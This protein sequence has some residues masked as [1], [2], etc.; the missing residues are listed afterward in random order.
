MSSIKR[1]LP[2]ISSLQQHFDAVL[3]GKL[4]DFLSS[5]HLRRRA[6]IGSRNY[7]LFAGVFSIA[8][9]FSLYFI[10]DRYDDV[11]WEIFLVCAILWLLVV[12]FS[13]RQ[14]LTDT[15]LLS[16]EMNM[17]LAPLISSA[18]NRTVIYSYDVTHREETEKLL[19]E[20]SLMTID[21]IKLVSDDVLT[22]YGDAELSMRELV[23]TKQEVTRQGKK[24]ALLLFKGVFV[25]AKLP[26]THQAETYISTD[27]DRSGFAHRTF[28]TTVLENTSI[29]E[30][31]LEWNDFEN[32]LHVA[33]NDPVV[34]RELL[35][36]DFMQD[37]YDWWLEHKLN[38][39]IAFKGDKFY[40]LLPE[41]SI[42]IG[43]STSSTKL[44]DIRKYACSLIRPLWRSIMLV[45]DVSDR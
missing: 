1:Q 27:N 44:E 3:R 38:I 16:K 24:D 30:T 17:A 29:K 4:A 8:I 6:V 37:L 22:V 11:V 13:A 2:N 5:T 28:W 33:S 26:F 21:D 35:T 9:L 25:I 10:H 40:M 34:A 41:T 19:R 14:W 15:K 31:V 23:V 32:K 39:R 42:K 36:T 45:E 7:A 20:S 43:F 18:L 12:L